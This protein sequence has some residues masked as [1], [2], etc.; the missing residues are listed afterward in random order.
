MKRTLLWICALIL[1]GLSV[2]VIGGSWYEGK[3]DW[4]ELALAAL[5]G[6]TAFRIARNLRGERPARQRD[7]SP[8]DRPWRR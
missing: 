5:F 8:E 6:V 7:A 3:A 2:S 4:V 1:G